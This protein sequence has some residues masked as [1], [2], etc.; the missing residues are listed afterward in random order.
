MTS[1]VTD[2]VTGTVTMGWRHVPPVPVPVPSPVGPFSTPKPVPSATGVTA[3]P[4]ALAMALAQAVMDAQRKQ[5]AALEPIDRIPPATQAERS[6]ERQQG[7]TKMPNALAG[8]A[9]SLHV[10][11]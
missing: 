8:Q 5:Q 1:R 9:A 10:L 11:K 7:E 2:G 4:S 6:R 3:P